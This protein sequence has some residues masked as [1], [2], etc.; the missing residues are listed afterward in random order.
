MTTALLNFTAKL[1]AKADAAKERYEALYSRREAASD[2][3][4]P[5]PSHELLSFALADWIRAESAAET[6]ARLAGEAT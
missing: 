1:R 5:G 4:Y 2:G 6:A 3:G